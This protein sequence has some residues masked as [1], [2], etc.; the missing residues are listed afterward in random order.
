MDSCG[1][2]L[3][4]S[5]FFF[6][7]CL[8]VSMYHSSLCISDLS[9]SVFAIIFV[10]FYSL[11]MSLTQRKFL[12]GRLFSSLRWIKLKNHFS[13]KCAGLSNFDGANLSKQLADLTHIILCTYVNQLH[14]Y[15]WHLNKSVIEW[16][17]SSLILDKLNIL[18]LY[19]VLEL[20]FFFFF[21]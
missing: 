4:A 1:L 10:L 14:G 12:T 3:K 20:L 2:E 9:L 17:Q 19:C 15:I 6:H 7:F 16:D 18:F 5:Y 13:V 21:F 11:S 8:S